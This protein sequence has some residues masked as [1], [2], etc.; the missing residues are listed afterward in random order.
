M[1]HSKGQH[2]KSYSEG[3]RDPRKDS[4]NNSKKDNKKDVVI[5][6]K[7]LTNVKIQNSNWSTQNTHQYN[8]LAII[9]DNNGKAKAMGKKPKNKVH[10]KGLKKYS[11]G[12]TLNKLTK[13]GILNRKLFIFG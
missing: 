12:Y 13:E 2:R 5:N 6:C 1:P 9:K 7:N 8:I 11:Q 10:E 3:V 4:R